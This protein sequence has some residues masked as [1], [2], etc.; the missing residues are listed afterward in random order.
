MGK[1]RKWN[2]PGIAALNPGISL[3]DA[4]ILPVTR[5][6][7]SGT[8]ESFTK[9]LGKINPE[10]KKNFG[11]ISDPKFADGICC[12]STKYPPD[13]IAYFAKQNSGVVGVVSSVPFTTVPFQIKKKNFEISN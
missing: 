6:E 9:I 10:W 7:S 11:A 1:I 12:N 5:F 8:V 13:V 2:D 4:K 3:P